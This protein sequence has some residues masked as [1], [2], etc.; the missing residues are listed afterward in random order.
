MIKYSKT[1]ETEL[2]NLQLTEQEKEVIKEMRRGTLPPSNLGRDDIILL[3]RLESRHY[4]LYFTKEQ[5]TERITNVSVR[6]YLANLGFNKRYFE[7][8]HI[9]MMKKV[10]EP[11]EP[12][13]RLKGETTSC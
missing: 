1:N 9:L 11:G 3:Q 2:A 5:R 12:K 10:F 13:W 8:I 7:E 4:E 6:N